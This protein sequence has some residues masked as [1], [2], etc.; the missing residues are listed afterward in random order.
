[1]K[2]ISREEQLY[3][4]AHKLHDEYFMYKHADEINS[5]VTITSNDALSSINKLLRAY[6]HNIK[7]FNSKPNKLLSWLWHHTI[8]PIIFYRTLFNFK[9]YFNI[10]DH[11]F[12]LYSSRDYLQYAENILQ[13]MNKPGIVWDVGCNAGIY[14][15]WFASCKFNTVVAFDISLTNIDLLSTSV[16]INNLTHIIRPIHAALSIHRTK[17]IP[18]K[19]GVASNKIVP[20]KGE[21]EDVGKLHYSLPYY[22]AVTYYGIPVI[23]KMDIEGGEKEFLRDAEF[24]SWAWNNNV[25]LIIEI[26]D[27][28]Y[29]Y[30][31]LPLWLDVYKFKVTLT[32][33]SLIIDPIRE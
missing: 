20:S 13:H 29:I 21:Y 25:K 3:I 6:E 8:P 19:N 9:V 17:Y 22:E 31:Y 30:T 5:E 2:K 1:M 33:C 16:K 23:I 11:S 32:G 18:P 4:E 28:D 12:A 15:F 14:S 24:I 7:Q 27:I 10:R 26:H